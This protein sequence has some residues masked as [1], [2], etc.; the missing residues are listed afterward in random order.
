MPPYVFLVLG[1]VSLTV[2]VVSTI[3]GESWARYGR[4]IYRAKEPTEFWGDVV[5]CYLC[6]IGFIGYFLYKVY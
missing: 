6:G 5:A 2:G 3:A 1:I 4:V